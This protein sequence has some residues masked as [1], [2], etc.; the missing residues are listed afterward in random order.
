MPEDSGS[1]KKLQVV[2]YVEERTGEGQQ[3]SIVYTP[4]YMT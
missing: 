2:K 3:E 4:N 1:Q